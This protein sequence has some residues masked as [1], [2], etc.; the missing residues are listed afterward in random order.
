MKPSYHLFL[1]FACA[2]TA[3]AA[4]NIDSV[5]RYAFGAEIGWLD[6]QGDADNGAVIGPHAC[7]GSI[8]GANVGWISLGNGAPANGIQYQ[9][10]SASDYGVNVDA[11]GNLRGY[12]YG[13]NIGWVNFEDLG[14]P[15]VDL[16]TGILGGYAYGANVGWISLSNAVAYVQEMVAPILSITPAGSNVILS[17]PS[18]ASAYTLESTSALGPNAI[19]TIV[20]QPPVLVGNEYTVTVPAAQGMQYFRLVRL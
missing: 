8:Y 17:W 11:V 5:N 6:W 9:N 18:W 20:P 1:C 4:S 10:A 7:S 16:K 12:A 19:W 3:C 13:A 2:F 14:T 15:K